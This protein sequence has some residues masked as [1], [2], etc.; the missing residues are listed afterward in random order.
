MCSVQWLGLVES[1]WRKGRLTGLVSPF[2]TLVQRRNTV[3]GRKACRM[4]RP[5]RTQRAGHDAQ[6][7]THDGDQSFLW[8]EDGKVRSRQVR[9]TKASPSQMQT[10][11]S[12]I[13]NDPVSACLEPSWP[14]NRLSESRTAVVSHVVEPRNLVFSQRPKRKVRCHMY[15][16][17]AASERFDSVSVSVSVCVSMRSCFNRGSHF[18][19]FTIAPPTATAVF[20]SKYSRLYRH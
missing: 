1:V 8:L 18:L 4:D 16:R 12:R 14:A 13:V 15:R 17:S 10:W 9:P 5:A 19:L 20:D 7:T 11:Q 2:G 6:R 3:S